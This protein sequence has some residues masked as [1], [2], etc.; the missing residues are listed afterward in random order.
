MSLGEKQFG[1]LNARVISADKGR[2]SH[3][4]LPKIGLQLAES[5]ILTIQAKIMKKE[6]VIS[7]NTATLNINL[8]RI[9]MPQTT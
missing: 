6:K 3:L 5:T 4:P 1:K 8:N 2:I 7:E 9:P